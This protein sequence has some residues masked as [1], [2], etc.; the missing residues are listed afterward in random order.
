MTATRIFHI[1][2]HAAWEAAR[3]QG[4][5]RPASLVTEGFIHFSEAHQ[6]S[7]VAN[8]FYAGQPGLVLLE[9]DTNLLRA[10]LRWE[11]PAGPPAETSA[12][13]GTLEVSGPVEGLFPHLY[14]P[15]DLVAVLAVHDF[16]PG[17]D[18]LFTLPTPLTTD[19]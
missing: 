10:E 18:G 8:A 15:L 3:Q 9:V 19:G 4:S 13:S 6:V 5:Y 17:P 16:S 7:Q 1:T 14:G 11:P 2:A 12:V